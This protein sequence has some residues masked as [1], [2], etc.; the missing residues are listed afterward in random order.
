MNT[1]VELDD[2]SDWPDSL[3]HMR[4]LDQLLRC[5]VC[6]EY[7]TTAMVTATCGH[8]FCSLCVRRCLTQETRC[9]SCRALLTESELNPNRLIDS[10][11]HSFKSGRLKLLAE[12]KTAAKRT[13]STALAQSRKSDNGH[14]VLVADNDRKRRRIGTRSAGMSSNSDVEAAPMVDL[15]TSDV[16]Q[17]ITSDLDMTTSDGDCEVRLSPARKRGSRRTS[18]GDDSDF[19]PEEKGHSTKSRPATGSQAS[20]PCPNC[21]EP[22][23]Q[24]LINLHLDR[25]L[26]GLLAKEAPVASTRKQAGP[27]FGLQQASAAKCALPRPTKL[28]YSLLSE[29]KLRRTLKDLGIPSKGDKQQMQARHVEWVNLYMANVDA[30]APV[31]HRLL[32]RRLAAWEESLAKPAEGSRPAIETESDVA[33]HAAKYA[34]SFTALIA[35]ASATRPKQAKPS[36]DPL[37]T[38]L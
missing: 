19:M 34:D 8:T 36:P 37:P 23:R 29:S 14:R 27:A 3:P 12:L 20:V 11:V 26:V 13:P 2:P 7:F 16:E 28:A 38:F 31:S 18:N 24:A 5:P 33:E 10:A 22:V 32:L 30:M 25:C 35:Q 15:T 6:K 17:M 1:L 9:P 21:Q 4:E